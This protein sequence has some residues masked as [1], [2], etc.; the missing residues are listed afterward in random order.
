[1]TDVAN[2]VLR[3]QRAREALDRRDWAL[4]PV[5]ADPYAPGSAMLSGDL[6][7]TDEQRRDWCVEPFVWRHQ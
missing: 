2:A 3:A 7:E 1:V 5:E 4:E 6:E